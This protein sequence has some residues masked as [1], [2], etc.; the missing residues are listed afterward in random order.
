MKYE[1]IVRMIERDDAGKIVGI[2]RATGTDPTLQR[3]LTYGREP[4]GADYKKVARERKP[5]PIDPHGVYGPADVAAFLNVSYNTAIRLMEKM[6]GCMGL[7][8]KEV[9]FKRR[10]RTLRISG[11]RLTEWKR[12]R[13]IA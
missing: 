9:R 11:L 2:L 5:L 10:R 13:Q 3:F 7:G 8:K 1:T 6:P 4:V 12:S